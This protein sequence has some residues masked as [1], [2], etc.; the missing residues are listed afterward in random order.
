MNGISLTVSGYRQEGKIFS[1]ALIPNTWINTS[2]QYLR[3][4]DLVNLEA[5]LLAKYAEKL[6]IERF[7]SN[8]QKLGNTQSDISKDWL[9][10][11]GWQ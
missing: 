8:Y 1:I 7:P 4:G 6:L 5:D 2:L 10:N 9:A 3:I 11:Q